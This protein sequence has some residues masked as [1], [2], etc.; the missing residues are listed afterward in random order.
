[1]RIKNQDI[2]NAFILICNVLILHVKNIKLKSFKSALLCVV[3]RTIFAV[4]HF[5]RHKSARTCQ[6]PLQVFIKHIKK[7]LLY[8]ITKILKFKKFYTRNHI[9]CHGNKLSC[10]QLSFN[11][12]RNFYDSISK[13]QTIYTFPCTSIDTHAKRFCGFPQNK[14]SRK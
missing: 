6:Q 9:S 1:M 12:S 10:N 2:R 5:F 3:H 14:C 11:I 7:I 8:E 4:L 13:P